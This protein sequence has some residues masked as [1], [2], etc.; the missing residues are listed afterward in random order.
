MP[1]EI[2]W[3]SGSPFAWRVLLALEH[4]G[5]PYESRLLQFSTQE[6]KRP[7]LLALNPRG[8]VPTLRDGDVVVYESVAI[9]AYLE[10]RFPARPLFGAD[11][12]EAGAI[13][14]A[15]CEVLSYLDDPADRVITALYYGEAALRV[16]EVRAALVQVEA[17]L[18]GWERRL[19]ARPWIAGASLSAADLALYPFVKSLARAA[20][21]PGTE[22]FAWPF[23][24]YEERLPRLAAWMK[25]IEALPGYER[26]YPPHWRG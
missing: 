26:T 15:V 11:A 10:R 20:S 19:E 23:L 2:F 24:P 16:D 5:V 7:E 3:G 25:S 17:E 13:W 21:K 14:Q 6:H 22:L 4:K 9:L 1:V 12:P 8:R 18:R